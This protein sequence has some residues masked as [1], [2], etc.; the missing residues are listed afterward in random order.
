MTMFSGVADTI[1]QSSVPLNVVLTPPLSLEVTS[2]YG[3]GEKLQQNIL[4]RL[5]NLFKSMKPGA[6]LTRFQLPPQFNLPKS[7]LQLYGESVYCYSQDLL[8]NCVEGRTPA[9]RFNAVVA[10]SIST[11]RPL[12]VGKAP[13][14]PILGETHHVSCGNLNVLLEQVSHHP[15]ISALHATD[16][17]RKFEL[18]WWQRPVPRFYGRSIEATIH[19]KRELKLLEL[20]ETYEMNSPKLC[21]RFFPFPSAE[22]SGD[23]LIQCKQSGLRATLCYRGKSLLGF[24]GSST[25]ITGRIG[26]IAH[27]GDLYELQGNWDQIITVKEMITGKTSILYDAKAVISNMKVPVVQNAEGVASTESALVWS[28]VS[29]SIMKGDWNKAREAKRCVEEKHRK[30]EGRW[31]AKHFTIS[32]SHQDSGEWVYLH[33]PQCVPPAPIILPPSPQR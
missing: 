13:Y 23:V 32:S 14:N 3:Q 2:G 7:Q 31:Q 29:E 11:T 26:H 5:W 19:G 24:K 21:L 1:D 28:E 17:A 20:N 10:W 12:I 8:S 6:D 33:R 30:E 4:T 25:R 27:G 15:P 18:N 16:E 9:E 22:W